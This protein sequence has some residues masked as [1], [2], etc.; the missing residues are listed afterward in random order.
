MRALGPGSVSSFLKIILDVVFAALWIGVAILSLLTLAALLLSFN[1]DLL[2]DIGLAT[3]AQARN[4]PL[5]ELLKNG[6]S[7]ASGLLAAALYL[8]GILVIVGSLRRIFTTLTVGDPFHPDNVARLRL[9]GLMLAGLE[10]GRYAF[11]GLSAW[12]IPGVNKVE[13]SFSLTA[14]F[15]VLVVFVLA[16]VFREGARLRREAELTI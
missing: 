1:P 12:L 16:E 5:S 8:G 14:W 10:L 15:S 13:P 7:L 6:P 11:W 2:G 9:I 3:D 4:G